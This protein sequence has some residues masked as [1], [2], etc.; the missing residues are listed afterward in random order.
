MSDTI[1][2]TVRKIQDDLNIIKRKKR[3]SQ[4]FDDLLKMYADVSH[5]CD[6][7]LLM[8]AYNH[9]ED[10]L[11]LKKQIDNY[12]KVKYSAVSLDKVILIVEFLNDIARGNYF[13]ILLFFCCLV[14]V[15]EF[16]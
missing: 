12:I 6:E 5:L 15:I 13:V 8:I 3:D 11:E 14:N 1:K 10:D 2:F 9:C 16:I 4:P 7:D